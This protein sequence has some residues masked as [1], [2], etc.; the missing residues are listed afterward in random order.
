MCAL[1]N[2]FLLV[3]GCETINP[4][5]IVDESLVFTKQELIASK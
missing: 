4:I 2:T 1:G 3:N 5:R